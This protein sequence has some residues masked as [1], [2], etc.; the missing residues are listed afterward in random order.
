MTS[1]KQY[2]Q[3]HLQG[4]YP[5]SEI[6]A[7]TN[8]ILEK[9][10]GMN[11]T[12]LLTNK[13]TIFSETMHADIRNITKRL[14]QYEPIQYIFGEMEFR[15]LSFLVNH[16][17]LIP[18]PETGELIDLILQ[19]VSGQTHCSV[20]DIGTGSGCIAISLAKERPLWQIS[21]WDI[22]VDAL[23]T[24]Q[25]NAHRNKVHIITREV[26]ILT[27]PT[28]E[29]R[30]NIIVSNPPYI[31]EK[32]QAEMEDNVLKYEPAI[33]LFVPND[34]PLL[35]YRHIAQYA[36]HHL[37]DGGFL[38]FETN[39]AYGNETVSMLKQYGFSDI[40]LHKD[41]SGNDRMVEARLYIKH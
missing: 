25:T 16:S 1:S 7:L 35:F 11:R 27:E 33:A 17:V 9:V 34:D 26:D 6:C 10:S 13:C 5:D 30:W 12:Q 15:G 19:K 2:I 41:I 39:R 24:A 40:E 3:Q 8:W 4:L 28:E 21:A 14:C 18:R 29:T 31:C 23:H 22:S 32:E 20:L 37:S 36:H 38:F